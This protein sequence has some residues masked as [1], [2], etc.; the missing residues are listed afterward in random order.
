MSHPYSIEIDRD[1]LR[2]LAKL[3]KPVRRRIQLAID[4]LA[5]DPRPHGARALTAAPGLLRLRVGDYRVIYQVHDDR[6][7]ILIACGRTTCGPSRCSGG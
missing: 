7:L 3:D 5:Q 6:L 1:A 2:S 4:R